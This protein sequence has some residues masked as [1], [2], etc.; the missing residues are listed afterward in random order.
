MQQTQLTRHGARTAATV[1]LALSIFCIAALWTASGPLAA[2]Y[3]MAGLQAYLHVTALTFLAGPVS[4]PLLALLRRE[5]RFGAVAVVNVASSAATA[6]VTLV[7]A[8]AGLSSMSFAWGSL[9]GGTTS[10][11][12][13]LVMC[14][15][16]WVLRPAVREW[17]ATLA[18][19]LYSS[20][21]GLVGKI[22]ESLPALILGRTL[23]LDAVGYY[24]RAAMV[25]QLP[26][27]CLLTGLLPVALPA[28]AAEVRAGRGL[29]APYLRGLS[30]ISVVQW[31]AFVLLAILAYPAVTL[32][33]GRQWT[34][35]APLVQIIALGSMMS[36]PSV[37]SAPT[38]TAIGALRDLFWCALIVLPINVAA[39]GV[40]SFFGV[41]AVA[42][43]FCVCVGSQSTVA[44]IFVCRHCLLTWR[45]LASAV[46]QSA[47][48]T[49]ASA[50]LPIF[51][52]AALG[53]RFDMS[54]GATVL[55][56]LEALAGWAAG[57]I[58]TGH[59][60]FV[61]F[62]VSLAEMQARRNRSPAP[63]QSAASAGG[64]GPG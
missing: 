63:D 43:S 36:A 32:L 8:I 6:L 1:M 5:M 22:T 9:C 40:A 52:V 4:G 29:K 64:S 45:D 38:L 14:E 31:P 24:N 25:C 16:R 47:I 3:R 58:A 46:R 62:R 42:W 17:R 30:F 12:L 60:L 19:G 57:L 59:P 2:F 39:I 44:L 20:G 15:D 13:A 10:A 26:D 53:F 28:M 27:K 55:I 56:A 49:T 33:L 34:P 21:A 35:I 41:E 54:S 50:A 51:T 48:V 37:L 18:F 23:S 7:L 11:I 61:E